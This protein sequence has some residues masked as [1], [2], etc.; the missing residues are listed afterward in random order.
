M[1]TVQL[2]LN[3]RPEVAKLIMD[4]I[5]TMPPEPDD[6]EAAQAKPEIKAPQAAQPTA[7]PEPQAT[8]EL[9]QEAPEPAQG[10]VKPLTIEDVRAVLAPLT[11]E[12]KPIAKMLQDSF[13]VAKLSQVPPERYPEVLKKAEGL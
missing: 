10:D 8:Q 11:Q 2:S 5:M 9:A 7:A 6:I 1:S 13:G 4:L 12:G 3:V